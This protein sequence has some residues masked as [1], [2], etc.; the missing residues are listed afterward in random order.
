MVRVESQDRV[1]N[2]EG[3]DGLVK[4]W[5]LWFIPNEFR[6]LQIAKGFHTCFLFGFLAGLFS[7]GN[8]GIAVALAFVVQK[9]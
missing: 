6:K 4:V 7:E 1:V 8:R 3:Q 9:L 5:H 2:G